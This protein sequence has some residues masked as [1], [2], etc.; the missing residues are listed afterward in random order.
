MYLVKN[1]F[2][3]QS[4]YMFAAA[5]CKVASRNGA[6]DHLKAAFEREDMRR[7]SRHAYSWTRCTPS[8]PEFTHATGTNARRKCSASNNHLPDSSTRIHDD[9]KLDAAGDRAR[10]PS[11]TKRQLDDI[12]HNRASTA[13][14]MLFQA[15]HPVSV[16]RL[17]RAWPESTDQRTTLGP[18]RPAKKMPS[19]GS[20]F[21][22]RSFNSRG[23]TSFFTPRRLRP[24]DSVASPQR[25]NLITT[26]IVHRR[27]PLHVRHLPRV[28]EVKLA[29]LGV[30]RRTS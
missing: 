20:H 17:R 12:F 7:G 5:Q 1:I 10:I 30:S 2:S 16:A 13:R 24:L 26:S 25:S 8:S 19:R 27:E 29:T 14:R 11:G 6:V 23:W 21:I 3:L 15:N 9:A 22:S 4:R 18:I 28:S